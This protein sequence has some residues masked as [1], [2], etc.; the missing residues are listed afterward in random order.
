MILPA[1]S[2]EKCA[3][4]TSRF[5]MQVARDVLGAYRVRTGAPTR[6]PKERPSNLP[7]ELIDHDGSRGTIDVEPSAHPGTLLLPDLPEP[8]VLVPTLEGERKN[9]RMF[10][11]LPDHDALSIASEHGAAAMHLGSFE[12]GCFYKLLA[13][14]A[15]AGAFLDPQWT[16]IWQPLLPDL[17]LERANNFDTLIGG[18]DVSEFD[19]DDGGFPAFYRSVDVKEKRYLVAYFKLFGPNRTPTYQVVTGSINI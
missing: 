8:S 19:D 9:F 4:I 15:H 3:A 17:I 18:T 2:C 1:A 5:E 7:L 10:F 13:K 12:I 6:R 11:A 16:K 14:I